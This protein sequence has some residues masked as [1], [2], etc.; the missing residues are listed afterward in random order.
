MI[1]RGRWILAILSVCPSML[2]LQV[3]GQEKVNSNWTVDRL[4]E[5][6]L[7]ERQKLRSGLAQGV[8]FE[9]FG[10]TF[11]GLTEAKGEATL[12][13][14]FD[15]VR[16]FFLCDHLGP[17]LSE[18]PKRDS[19]S[20]GNLRRTVF[21]NLPDRSY[22]FSSERPNNN[23]LRILS[24]GFSRGAEP[25]GSFF[26]DIRAVGLYGASRVFD[27][28]L[29][30]SAMEDLLN[31]LPDLKLESEENGVVRIWSVD[32]E[33]RRRVSLWIDTRNGFVPVKRTEEWDPAKSV[34]SADT[35]P[36]LF[37]SPELIATH[38]IG[39]K[40][41]GGVYV[42]IAYRHKAS[43]PYLPAGF[44]DAPDATIQ[45]EKLIFEADYNFT[46]EQ[47]NSK[48]AES[49]FDYHSFELPLGTVVFDDRTATSQFVERLGDSDAVTLV[50]SNRSRPWLKI[51][52]F[53]LALAVGIAFVLQLVR[54]RAN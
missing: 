18:T 4:C 39:W 43:F 21:C 32:R 20:E 11:E 8:G 38:D 14:K 49:D 26:T 41:I 24:P 15:F 44:P 22:H 46:W 28:V 17:Y 5:A 3:S 27:G 45:W 42:P 47:I 10:N 16:G 48:F 40:E 13:I 1:N 29:L 52:L 51:A 33:S 2:F 30:D 35:H 53:G 23:A 50:K 9:K 6:M 54:R 34:A 12:N 19:D 31:F 7:A 25:S 37:I 36:A